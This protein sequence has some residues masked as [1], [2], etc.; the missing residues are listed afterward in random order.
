[1]FKEICSISFST[2]DIQK[3]CLG[4]LVTVWM[5][6]KNQLTTEHDQMGLKAVLEKILT[7]V[8]CLWEQK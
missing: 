5:L 7:Q 1:V 3:L 6:N 4:R 2:A 8:R